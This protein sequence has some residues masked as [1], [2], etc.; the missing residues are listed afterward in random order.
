MLPR[1]G[2]LGI[3]RDMADSPLTLYQAEWC[4]FSAAVREVLTE[5]GIDVVL[6]QVEPWPEQRGRLR[7]MAGTDEIPV[8]VAEDGR[9]FCGTREIF[10]HLATRAGGRFAA[11]HRRRYAEHREARQGDA[12]GRLLE[13]FDRTAAT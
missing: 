11:D 6:R 7:E 3:L 12:T 8:L 9:V 1:P 13:H 5:L 4:P 2:R 10:V